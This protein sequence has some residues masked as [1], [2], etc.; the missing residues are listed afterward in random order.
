MVLQ[1]FWN[2][3]VLLLLW[4]R[5][6]FFVWLNVDV[7]SAA[8]WGYIVYFYDIRGCWVY[9][10][11]SIFYLCLQKSFVHFVFFNNN[12]IS[13]KRKSY[14]NENSFQHLLDD[15]NK[16]V[17]FHV[18]GKLKKLWGYIFFSTMLACTKKNNK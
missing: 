2:N 5:T 11:A 17:N 15:K 12:L 18:F 3:D 8:S 6:E 7:D 14:V 10:G 1:L 4:Q 13:N 16:C 9:P